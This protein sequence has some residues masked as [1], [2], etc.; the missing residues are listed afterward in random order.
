MTSSMADQSYAAAERYR[1]EWVV[2]VGL[3][4]AHLVTQRAGTYARTAC[5]RTL[6]GA[7]PAS[8]MW[9]GCIQCVALAEL[10]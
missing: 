9:D 1:G 6:D 10:A 4:R 3:G 7:S 2:P 5:G 8:R